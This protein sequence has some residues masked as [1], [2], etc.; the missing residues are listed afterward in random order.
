MA[1]NNSHVSVAW[2]TPDDRGPMGQVEGGGRKLVRL[3]GK[4]NIPAALRPGRDSVQPCRVSHDTA[5]DAPGRGVLFVVPI[6]PAVGR[7]EA[8][9][10]RTAQDLIEVR[11][12]W[13]A[14]WRTAIST[15][16]GLR[17]LVGGYTPINLRVDGRWGDYRSSAEPKHPILRVVAGK[18][19]VWSRVWTNPGFTWDRLILP[20]PELGQ[21]EELSRRL[22]AVWYHE[23]PIEAARER[24]ADLGLTAESVDRTVTTSAHGGLVVTWTGTV[25]GERIKLAQ[26]YFS[27]PNFE[28]GDEDIPEIAAARAAWSREYLDRHPSPKE[29]WDA[30]VSGVVAIDSHTTATYEYVSPDERGTRIGG[31]DRF[32]IVSV[33]G[34]KIGYVPANFWPQA[35]AFFGLVEGGSHPGLSPRQLQAFHY[36]YADWT[37]SGA[38]GPRGCAAMLAEAGV[39]YDPVA[40]MAAGKAEWTKRCEAAAKAE[41]DRLQAASE[42]LQRAEAARTEALRQTAEAAERMRTERY[43][44]LL[45][46]SLVMGSQ[47][48]GRDV[49][50]MR[51]IE[52]DGRSEELLT[53]LRTAAALPTADLY[54]ALRTVRNALGVNVGLSPMSNN[55]NWRPDSVSEVAKKVGV[56]Q[57]VATLIMALE[58][59][60]TDPAPTPKAAPAAQTATRTPATAADIA[61]LRELLGGKRR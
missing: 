43:G 56:G 9:K 41:C 6:G 35:Q 37:T 45:H 53:E 1:K 3:D 21:G 4:A 59:G 29:G 13:E 39:D 58:S 57:F 61:A 7:E 25:C 42:A 46:E 23:F 49:P 50:L 19:E 54:R 12:E 34:Q 14:A 32:M 30:R 27:S 55:A 33:D 52:T 17:R 60:S 47:S 8:R 38:L 15:P 44:A 40:V 5:P 11:T 51:L 22:I 26:R 36:A 48:W 20:L 18:A 2:G 31:G 24:M 10:A 28:T 16:E